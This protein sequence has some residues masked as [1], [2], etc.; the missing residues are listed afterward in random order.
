VLSAYRQTSSTGFKQQDKLK[1]ET[2]YLVAATKNLFILQPSNAA[3]I[4]QRAINL[5]CMTALPYQ[6]SENI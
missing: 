2:L 5:I 6:L 1:D 4:D 3:N